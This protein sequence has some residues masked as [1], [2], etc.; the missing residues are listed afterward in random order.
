MKDWIDEGSSSLI[1]PMV[2]ASAQS[3]VTFRPSDVQAMRRRV[4]TSPH[5]GIMQIGVYPV[6]N[7]GVYPGG[8]YPVYNRGVYTQV[9]HTRCITVVYTQVVYTRVCTGYIPRWCIPGWCIAQ[10]TS[11]LHHGGY[12]SL[13]TYPTIPPWVYHYATAPAVHMMSGMRGAQRR[14]PGLCWENS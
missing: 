12:T 11:L 1:L 6:Y 3:G 14:G 2:E 5:A 10:Y 4:D 7:S 13:C 8:A 9:V